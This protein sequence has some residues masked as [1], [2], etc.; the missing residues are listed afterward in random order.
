M[1]SN[2]ADGS[3][4]DVNPDLIELCRDSVAWR[5]QRRR[6]LQ[7]VFGV[8]GAAP[9]PASKVNIGQPHVTVSAAS[10]LGEAQG[11]TREEQE[12]YV[13]Q[14]LMSHKRKRE[15]SAPSAG[16]DTPIPVKP[17]ALSVKARLLQQLKGDK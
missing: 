9:A 14:Q 13:L 2:D 5:E 4:A 7:Q 12:A 16:N 11:R 6:A 8:G 10:V 3:L 17:S 1:E 15:E